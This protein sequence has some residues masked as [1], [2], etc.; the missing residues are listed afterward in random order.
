M[1]DPTGQSAATTA[2]DLGG[3]GTA[4]PAAL[5]VPVIPAPTAGVPNPQQTLEAQLAEQK[6][7]Q[8]GL[9]KRVAQLMQQVANDSKEKKDLADKL[10]AAGQTGQE[11]ELLR[12]KVAAS[13][14]EKTALEQQ[15]AAIK[16]QA[17]RV[18]IVAS[19]FPALAPLV[20][21]GALP[22]A[23]DNDEFRAKL[24]GMADAF[25]AN[26]QVTFQTMAAGARPPASPPAATP[27][28]SRA[29]QRDMLAALRDNDFTKYNT[30]KEQWYAA[31]AHLAK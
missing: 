21:A 29:I 23:K 16:V 27:G 13:D 10:A 8:S 31:T 14:G 7:I 17:E 6:A 5:V 3:G 28:D 18:G 4:A 11:L 9:D 19:E 20:A 22:E 24:K 30:L 2:A 12:Q 1:A 25:N 26:A 15:I